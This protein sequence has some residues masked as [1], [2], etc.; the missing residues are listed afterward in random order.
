M[1]ARCAH[2]P[3]LRGWVGRVAQQSSRAPSHCVP[4][5]ADYDSRDGG[6]GDDEDDDDENGGGGR[7]REQ[8]AQ[9]FCEKNERADHDFQRE[10]A[11]LSTWAQNGLRLCLT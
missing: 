5:D 3:L 10:H 6:N 11:M 7:D 2:T 8:P 9:S 1:R 4:L